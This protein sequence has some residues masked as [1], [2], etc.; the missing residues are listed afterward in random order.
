[1]HT[2][3]DG[4]DES[5]IVRELQRRIELEAMIANL[6]TRFV[7]AEHGRVSEEIGRALGQVA[8]F[9]GAERG[10]MYRFDPDGNCARIAHDWSADPHHRPEPALAEIRRAEAPEVLDYFLGR[11]TL[12]SPTP[13]SL[14]HGFARLN[15]LPGVDRVMS[16]ISV[17]VVDGTRAIGIL[18]F[19]SL[20]VER[21]WLEEDLRLLGLLGEIIGSGIRRAETESALEEA[22][23]RAEAA[24]RAKSEFL[25]NMSHELRTPLNGILGYAQLLARGSTLTTDDAERVAAIE[26]CGANLL[27]LINDLLD[28]SRIE[29][30]QAPVE[31]ADCSPGGLLQELAGVARVRAQQSGLEFEYVVVGDL[32][33][34]VRTDAR[35]LRQILMNLLGNAVK[36]TR[37]GR[38]TLRVGTSAVDRDTCILRIEVADTGIGIA[39]SDQGRVFERFS[40]VRE[41]KQVTEG[42]GLGLAICRKLAGLLGGTLQLN[43]SPG[44]G[45]TFTVNL[46]VHISSPS[47]GGPGT[48]RPRIVGYAGRRRRVLIADDARDSRR[49]FRDLLEPLGFAVDEVAS[50]SDAVFMVRQSPPDL[51]FMDVVMPPNGGLSAVREIRSADGGGSSVAIVAVSATAFDTTRQEA[52]SAGCDAFVAKPVRLDDVLSVAGSALDL[53]WIHAAAGGETPTTADS[54]PDDVARELRQFARMGDMRALKVLADALAADDVRLQP[55]ARQLA[56]HIHRYDLEGVRELIGA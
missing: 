25:A 21:H 38:I 40:Q 14:P 24:D 36:F 18:C 13:E 48:G 37:V 28:L 30:G 20:L 50:G 56:E 46:P 55:L 33:T 42:T 26:R 19:H 44:I 3:T 35:K 32:P 49:I 17:P 41:A 45:S 34:T 6:S 27:S 22:R 29:A 7:A 2:Q 51:I 11:R 5:R 47:V 10:L 1:M 12:N 9:I 16:R 15:E 43:S 4:R 52:I 39:E 31:L 54:L 8:A 53:E 23:D